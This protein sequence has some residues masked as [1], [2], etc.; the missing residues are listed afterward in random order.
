MN[1][2]E[3]LVPRPYGRTTERLFGIHWRE[4]PA[5][6]HCITIL[7]NEWK[8]E[9]CHNANSGATDVTESYR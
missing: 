7:H 2:Q 4:D 5:K 6:A 8:S 9:S 3:T 1:P